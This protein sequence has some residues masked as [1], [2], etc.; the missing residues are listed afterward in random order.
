M[1][2]DRWATWRQEAE[3][4]GEVL[5]QAPTVDKC[6]RIPR[7]NFQRRQRAVVEALDRAG[8]DAGVVYSDEHYDGDVPYLGG[9]SNITIEPVA[10]VIGANG[11]H[12]LAGLEGGYVAEQLASRSGAEVHKV[13]ILKLADEDYPI[14]AERM[15]DVIKAAVGHKPRRIG[16]L[17]PRAVFPV[18][19]YS[20]LVDYLGDERRLVDAQ[21]SYYRIKYEKSDDEMALIAQASRIADVMLAGMLAVLKPDMLETQVSSWGYL[22]GQELGVEGMGFDIMVTANEANRTLIG[23]ALNRPIHRGD[24]VHLG[25]APKVDGLTAC[26]RVSVI[27]VPD[28]SEI[29]DDQRYWLDFVE[30]A[31]GVGLEAYREVARENLPAKRQEQALVDYFASRSDEVSRRVGRRVDL[32]RQKPYTGTHNAGYTE[33]Q[34]FYGAITLDS[35]Q[36]LGRQIVTMLDVAVRGIGDRWVDVVIPDLDY[37]LVEK[38]LGKTGADVRVLNRLPVNVQHLVGRPA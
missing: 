32:V 20:Y 4:V 19:L 27:A 35:H 14:R 18:S 33:C 38:T 1:S 8:L 2:V 3:I 17:T 28:P 11:F 12:I 36:P 31:F 13:E 7:S 26:E 21:E 16:L 34:E 23:K 6:A 37:V 24:Y 15:E 22:I 30:E 5:R 29:T 9:N 10:G 25:V